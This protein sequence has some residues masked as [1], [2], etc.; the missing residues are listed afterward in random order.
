MKID[1]S[2]N[3]NFR[4]NLFAQAGKLNVARLTTPEDIQFLKDFSKRTDFKKLMPQ[5]D[6]NQTDR[7]HEILEYAIDHAEVPGNT[8][9]ITISDGKL[10]GIITG[11]QDKTTLID[12]ICS[13]PAEIGKK[14]KFAG[15]TLFYKFFKDFI[16]YDGTRMKLSAIVNGPY[17]T[18]NK[19]KEFGFKETCNCTPTTVEMTA[20]KYAI[21]E[22]MKNLKTLIQYKEFPEKKVKLS[23]II[24]N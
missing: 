5:I 3:I 2:N 11:F 9:Y 1:H 16:E 6:K 10:C 7:W 18:I 15:K 4:A 20:N 17:N 22:A 13:I 21:K 14:V 19:Y 8:T 24:K 23:D 12:C